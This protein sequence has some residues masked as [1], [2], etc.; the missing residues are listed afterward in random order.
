MARRSSGSVQKR[1]VE[2][3]SQTILLRNSS[4]LT[5]STLV[6]D[7][8]VLDVLGAGVH[9]QVEVRRRERHIAAVLVTTGSSTFAATAALI[10]TIE[11]ILFYFGAEEKKP[12]DEQTRAPHQ[13]RAVLCRG[14]HLP[15]T[16]RL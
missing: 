6:G 4:V 9:L 7:L 13:Q 5:R 8:G 16:L 3:P 10:D 15:H 1:R 11:A 2:L 14:Q 12:A